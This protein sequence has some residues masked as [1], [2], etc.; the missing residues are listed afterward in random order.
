MIIEPGSKKLEELVTEFWSIRLRYS[1]APP[2]VTIYSRE[3][4]I[5]ETGN[6]KT[7]ARYSP[8]E[9]QLSLLPN[10]IAHI[11]LLLHELAHHLQSSQL[12]SAEFLRTYDKYTEEFG[13]HNNP[14]EVEAR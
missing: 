13:Y 4:Y 1:F 7:V 3:E 10:I 11:E 8:E 5:E 9:G 12:G 14:Y 6:D 2:K